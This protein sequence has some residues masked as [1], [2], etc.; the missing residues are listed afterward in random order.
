MHVG[1]LVAEQELDGAVLVRLEPEAGAEHVAEPIVLRRR[2]R[3][4]HRPLLEELALD[5]LHAARILKQGEPR[6]ALHVRDRGAELVDHELHP[7][8][9]RLV[10]DDEQHLVVVRRARLLRREQPLEPR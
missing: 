10:L 7:Q 4:E 1:V 5:L 8:L 9:R 6:S 2:Q 3:L